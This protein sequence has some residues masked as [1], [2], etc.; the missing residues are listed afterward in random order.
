MMISPTGHKRMYGITVRVYVINYRRANY[1]N[2][3]A[4]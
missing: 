2:Y 4:K 1:L 3:D